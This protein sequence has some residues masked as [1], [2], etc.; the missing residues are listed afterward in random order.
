MIASLRL[1]FAIFDD[2]SIFICRLLSDFCGANAFELFVSLI[3]IGGLAIVGWRTICV[4]GIVATVAVAVANTVF[5][6]GMED[7]D[8]L[9]KWKSV[10]FELIGV[11]AFNALVV[12]VA[13][14][15]AAND[16]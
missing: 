7:A 6:D 5:D 12:V 3:F 16:K 15:A 8:R 9:R 14:A 11:T 4:D 13:A 10:W 2:L 1:F